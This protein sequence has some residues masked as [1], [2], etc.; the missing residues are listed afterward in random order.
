MN[1]LKE[2]QN[3]FMA[4]DFDILYDCPILVGKL[5]ALPSFFVKG[6]EHRFIGYQL[7]NF[8]RVLFMQNLKKFVEAS[9]AIIGD[10]PYKQYTFIAIGPG[11]GGIEHLN[12]TTFGF[13]W[14]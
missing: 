1:L 9:V 11:R 13:Q 12:N 10:I 6:I 8:D 5:E 2:S 4:P 7:G 3:E 14:Q